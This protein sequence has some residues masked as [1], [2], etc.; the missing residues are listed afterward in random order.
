MN[1]AL[2]RGERGTLLQGGMKVQEAKET[3][4]LFIFRNC[5][6]SEDLV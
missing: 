1:Q 3:M 2:T 6:K 4:L 5:F